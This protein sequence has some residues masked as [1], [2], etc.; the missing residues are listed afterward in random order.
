MVLSACEC[1]S[2]QDL[3]DSDGESCFSSTLLLP[4]ESKDCVFATT[5][6]ASVNG[7]R[8][9][10]TDE[11]GPT[12]PRL[13]KRK[14]V[15]DEESIV[16]LKKSK[17]DTVDPKLPP[18][19]S[20]D[21]GDC[22]SV[23]EIIKEDHSAHGSSPHEI[24]AERESE[25]ATLPIIV[26]KTQSKVFSPEQVV[27]LSPKQPTA[28]TLDNES[29]P[30]KADEKQKKK[31]ISQTLKQQPP[32]KRL[33]AAKKQAEQVAKKT[34]IV[35]E[36]CESSTF[37]STPLS[38]R[39]ENSHVHTVNKKEIAPKQD[40]SLPKQRTKAWNPPG[41]MRK[42][43]ETIKYAKINIFFKGRSLGKES[44]P[45]SSPSTGRLRLGLSRKRL[46]K[47]LHPEIK[48]KTSHY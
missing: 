18:L 32:K 42:L 12:R 6:V 11:V 8:R 25:K 39:T 24:S 31:E 47:P 45:G 29:R 5:R 30:I 14:I 26:D 17:T 34:S 22:A 48:P 16:D 23:V 46:A 10:S 15:D 44:T 37:D 20:S 40:E 13:F 27:A 33:T 3:T 41:K 28:N 21:G 1:T 43:S 38:I 7:N 2:S 19:C 4:N 35:A 9:G 36:K